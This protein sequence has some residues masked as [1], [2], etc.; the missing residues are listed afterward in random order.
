MSIMSYFFSDQTTQ[1]Q[2]ASLQSQQKQ[3]SKTQPDDLE[4]HVLNAAIGYNQG[5]SQPWATDKQRAMRVL[6]RKGQMLD[7]NP[8]RLLKSAQ[9]AMPRAKDDFEV[10]Y[11]S[12]TLEG[13]RYEASA[14]LGQQVPYLNNDAMSGLEAGQLFQAEDGWEDVNITKSQIPVS[15]FSPYD[16]PPKKTG[17]F[18][19][20]S[21]KVASALFGRGDPKRPEISAPL[22]GLRHE[23]DGEAGIPS[24]VKYAIPIL[25][26]AA[27]L[28]NRADTVQ[29][30]I[31]LRQLK[32]PGERPKLTIATLQKCQEQVVS[33]VET[34]KLRVVGS[35]DRRTELGD[36]MNLR[37]PTSEDYV[38]AETAYIQQRSLLE[39][40]A[41]AFIPPTS[42]ADASPG[43]PDRMT[44][45]G[46]FMDIREL[47]FRGHDPD[48][49]SDD[50]YEQERRILQTRRLQSFRLSRDSCMPSAIPSGVALS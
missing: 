27:E 10:L 42:A 16:S 1:A 49:A 38:R 18:R 8:H 15:R 25:T 28:A 13:I 29:E 43:S 9:A 5:T 23:P 32:K 33:E 7:G 24:A 20:L 19:S 6:T 30:A 41:D 44:E 3:P 26:P 12:E 34:K 35:P 47:P 22:R 45:L 37:D 11:H 31:G 17:L 40:R 36:F 21:K 14:G 4:Y 2:D 48:H 50:D 39:A 46:D